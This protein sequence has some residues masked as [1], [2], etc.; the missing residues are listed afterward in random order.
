MTV[1]LIAGLLLAPAPM[2]ASYEMECSSVQAVV[3]RLIR[4]ESIDQK[5]K[6]EIYRELKNVT[7]VSCNVEVLA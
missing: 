1:F 7:P 4:T 5:L 6:I 2:Q 3:R